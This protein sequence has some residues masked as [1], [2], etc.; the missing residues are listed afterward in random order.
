MNT[1]KIEKYLLELGESKFRLDQ[2]K[3]AVYQDGIIDFAKISTLSKELR[4]KLNSNFKILSAEPIEVLISQKKDSIKAL[5]KLSD[6]NLIE[7]VLISPKSNV[8]SACVSCQVGCAVGCSFCATGKI[9]FKRNLTS[10]EIT[11][12]V[13]FWKSY[14]RE[15][16]ISGNFSNIVYMG[17]GEP[18]LNFEEV[19]KSLKVLI[20]PDF[21][22]FGSRKISVSTSGIM[23]KLEE[24]SEKFPQVNLALSLHSANPEKRSQLMPINQKYDL[25][26]IKT[27]LQKY[28]KKYKRKIFIEYL[29]IDGVNDGIEDAKILVD[30]LK[31]IGF[32]YLLHVNLIRY[33]DTNDKYKPSSKNKVKAFEKHLFDQKINVTIRKS[34]GQDIYAACG[35]LAGKK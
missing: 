24:F 3:K 26:K 28:L 22:N 33:N 10:E 30:Y 11:D 32:E 14:L 9:G 34:L 6:G 29:M 12:Q 8:W 35:Q 25:E 27:E 31:L 20:S 2:I 1:K 7:T 16:N 17:M 23:D 13:L 4:E 19:E 18:F 15:N 5:L 21:F